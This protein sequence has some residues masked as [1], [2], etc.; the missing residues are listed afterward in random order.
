M[1]EHLSSAEAFELLST[2]PDAVLVDVRTQAEWMFVGVPDLEGID[3]QVHTLE[4]N[5]YPSGHNALF[6]RQVVEAVPDKA[7]PVL[8]LCRSGARS[9]AA[10]EALTEAGY[11]RPINVTAGFE[12]DLNAENHRE[13]GWK[14]S[15]LAW[16]Q[17]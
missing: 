9:L 16:K 13:G 6:V 8:L 5:Q 3:K 2:N 10:A 14:T 1:I 17:G 12:G 4:W 11:A 7:A 15:G